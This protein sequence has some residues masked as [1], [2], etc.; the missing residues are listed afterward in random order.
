LSKEENV[1]NWALD[2]T[3]GQLKREFFPPPFHADDH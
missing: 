1:V 2:S 3:T